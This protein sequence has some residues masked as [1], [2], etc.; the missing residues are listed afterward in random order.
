MSPRRRRIRPTPAPISPMKRAAAR[1]RKQ[2]AA[3]QARYAERQ[4]ENL[5]VAPMPVDNVV[6]EALLLTGQVPSDCEDDR[7]TIANALRAF[8][9]AWA[10]GVVSRHVA[11]L[12][13]QPSESDG[14]V[15]S[16]HEQAD[17]HHVR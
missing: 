3:R 2:A 5:I 12:T 11:K 4:R 9:V 10:H 6:I 14:A 16:S 15:Q 13:R 7:V 17:A 1:K 8:V